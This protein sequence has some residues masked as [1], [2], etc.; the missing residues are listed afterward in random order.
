MKGLFQPRRP[1]WSLLLWIGAL[2]SV[3]LA[4]ASCGGDGERG[5]VTDHTGSDTAEAFVPAIVSAEGFTLNGTELTAVVENSKT[6]WRL[7]TAIDVTPD[8]EWEVYLDEACTQAVKNKTLELQE[9][10]NLFYI[11]VS[12]KGVDVKYTLR[13]TRE[14]T[15]YQVRF[16]SNGG[17]FVE[18]Q[19]L[20]AG[21][22]AV[23]AVPVREGWRF[24][25][26]HQVNGEIY[27]F[28]SPITEDLHLVAYW[29]KTSSSSGISNT[30]LVS[31]ASSSAAI[32][33]V[34]KDN[35]N[36]QGTRPDQVICV[37]TRTA[38]EVSE[39]FR[40]I[41]RENDVQWEDAEA[42]GLTAQG[43]SVA[44]GA[45]KWT[46]KITGLPEKASDGTPYTYCFYQESEPEG[47]SSLQSGTSVVNTAEGFQAEQ[48]DFAWL[49][50]ANGRLY[51]GAGNVVVLKGVVT[52][53][54][55]TQRFA[56]TTSL[57]ALNALRSIGVNCIRCT[58]QL[59]NGSY[60]YVYTD[61]NRTEPTSENVKASL[62]AQLK[63]A[64]DNASALGMYCIVDWGVLKENP[65]LYVEEAEAFFREMAQTYADN[66]YVL[67]E[68]C[69]E[70]VA[71]WGNQN[72]DSTSIRVYAEKMIGIIRACGAYNVVIVAPNH[73]ATA[74][75]VYSEADAPSDDPVDDP[76]R[77]ELAYNVAYTF[78]CYPY[79][80]AY[81]DESKLQW[82][83]SWKLRDALNAGYTVITTE[84]SPCDGTLTNPDAEAYDMGETAK[85]INLYLENDMSFCYFRFYSPHFTIS[86]YTETAM[87]VPHIDLSK[88]LW[89]V[90]DLTTCG[91]WFY[92]LCTADGVI[93]KADF[94]AERVKPD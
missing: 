83:Y 55:G 94:D 14:K 86:T 63:T 3:S 44:C 77:M 23:S 6:I 35:A 1:V 49:T 88:G 15:L 91:K 58:V 75:S 89:T 5:N 93:H 19:S 60:A 85:Y 76:I 79:N 22:T 43:V 37:L 45:G 27:D 17:S 46:V 59:E 52:V 39:R 31:F 66:P 69:N 54:V 78:H 41:V 90:D 47:Y 36:R 56:N 42:N 8:S 71:N 81:W 50:T 87:F 21:E 16:F 33:I 48:D 82:S 4:V 13:V 20:H 29:E 67:Y 92:D 12:G 32:N 2:L 40:V 73:S 38:G 25:G 24:L 28:T 62:I 18:T 26:W 72:G 51:D 7:K 80:Y 11:L 68:V 9:G 65:N 53:N 34:W 61:N 64:I 74:L 10:E 57:S 84:M 70:P 30:Q